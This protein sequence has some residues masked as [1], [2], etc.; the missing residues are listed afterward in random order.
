MCPGGCWQPDTWPPPTPDGA[1][2][3]GFPKAPSSGLGLREPEGPGFLGAAVPAP[4]S[5]L[6]RKVK[7]CSGPG[8]KDWAPAAGPTQ[9]MGPGLY[10]AQLRGQFAARLRGLMTQL[11]PQNKLSF[12]A[13]SQK[14]P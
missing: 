13:S 4:A 8:R 2:G 1:I 14:A 6:Q 10:T 7:G 3:L 9:A 5:T 11:G 12:L